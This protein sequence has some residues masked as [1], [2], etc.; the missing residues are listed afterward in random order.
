METFN[1]LIG[2]VFIVVGLVG[3]VTG[4]VMIFKGR[5]G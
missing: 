5:V 2:P 1:S 3:I 4:F